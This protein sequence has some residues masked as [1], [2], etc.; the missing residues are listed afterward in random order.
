MKRLLKIISGLMASLMLLIATLSLSAC[1]E[2][3]V[4]LTVKV[5]VCNYATKELHDEEEYTTLTIDL[6]R[7]LAPKT[8]DAIVKYINDGYYND[9]TFYMESGYS[10]QIMVGS[11]KI[12]GDK[13]VQNTIKPS[14]VGEFEHRAVQ[15][16]NLKNQNGALGLWRSWYASD[17]AGEGYKATNGMDSGTS[18]LYIP[19]QDIADYDGYFCVFGLMDMNN[20]VNMNTLGAISNALSGANYENYVIYYTGDYDENKQ[21]ENFGLTFNMVTEEEFENF[22]KKQKDEIFVAEDGQYV[23]FNKKTVKIPSKTSTG[24][25]GA[26]IVS[27][28]VD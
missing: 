1:S 17:N 9:T 20:E 27:I 5:Q 15:G 21:S 23:E 18:T 2:D 11:L 13:Y 25:A 10:S 16:S 26:K 24:E 6:Y 12:D 28:T 7:H 8:V 19:T 4:T 3:I 14:I 22:D